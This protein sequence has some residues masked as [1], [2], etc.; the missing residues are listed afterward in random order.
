MMGWRHFLFYE[1]KSGAPF[2]LHFISKYSREGRRIRPGDPKLKIK[3]SIFDIDAR[4]MEPYC[5]SIPA[6]WFGLF[7]DEIN[8]AVVKRTKKYI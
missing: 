5:F 6:L 4:H 3:V 7:G 2:G 1:I 8:S